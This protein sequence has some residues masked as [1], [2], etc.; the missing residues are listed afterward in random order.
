VG[1]HHVIVDLDGDIGEVWADARDP[2][3]PAIRGLHACESATGSLDAAPQTLRLVE[4][5][6]RANAEQIRLC[7]ERRC[8]HHAP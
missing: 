6:A 3:V 5:W 7:R 8:D 4:K 2:I 1:K